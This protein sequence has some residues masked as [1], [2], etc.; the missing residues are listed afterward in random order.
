MG[1]I[2]EDVK[3]SGTK[4]YASEWNKDHVIDDD[5]DFD[6]NG[7]INLKDPT[8]NQDAATKI[9]VDDATIGIGI[10]INEIYTGT[11]YN[12]VNTNADSSVSYE[13]IAQGATTKN[14]ARVIMTGQHVVWGGDANSSLTQL[15]AQ[16]KETGGAYADIADYQTMI[17]SGINGF[18]IG[19]APSYS[20]ITTLTAGMK[21]NGFQ[22]KVFCHAK[23]GLTGGTAS[24]AN[25]QTIQETF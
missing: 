9:Y 21:A 15:K 6:S 19:T 18:T 4:G 10:S 16:I 2:H 3:T 14:Y 7:I 12:L 8:N 5:V 24:F 13:M 22:I 20:L 17:S 23:G 1:I 11:G 25:I